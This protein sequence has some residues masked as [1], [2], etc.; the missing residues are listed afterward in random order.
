[1]PPITLLI[2][3]A[4]SACNLKCNY[5]FYHSL[6]DKREV[7]SYGLMNKDTLES[8]VKKALEEADDTCTFAFQGG[9]PTLAGLDFFE[10]LIKLQSK[11]NYKDLKINN[12]IQTNGT[13]INEDWAIFLEKNNFLVGLSLDGPKDIHNINRK[14][15]KGFDTFN[16][17]IK[18]ANLFKKYNI[19]FN[20]LCVITSKS[21]KHIK[22]IYSYFKSMNFKYIQFINCLDPLYEQWGTYSY[23]LKPNDFTYFLK[24]LFDEWYNDF[25]S[26]NYIS[27]RYFDSLI[28]L[29]VNGRSSSCGMNG[30]CTCQFVIESDGSVYPCDFYVVDKWNLGNIQHMSLKDLY[31]NKISQDFI[32]SSIN[33]NETCNRCKWFQLCKGGCR[34]Y[35]EP[36]KDNSL[37][38]NYYCE[39]YKEFFEYA[40]PRLSNA[41][42]RINNLR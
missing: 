30:M 22:K 23:S 26:G 32:K 33:I 36:L 31:E 27:I 11:Y 10:D 37:S 34:R 28:E 3:P 8:I 4:S 39:S 9:E 38:L 2:K 19:Q 18:T 21:C 25:I 17:V 20:I 42:R 24:T 29:M 5:C 14:D 35:R 41:L 13:L 1:M 12:T 16:K 7:K 40:I 15:C 6:S